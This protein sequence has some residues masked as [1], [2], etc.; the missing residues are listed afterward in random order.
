MLPWVARILN[1]SRR[2]KRKLSPALTSTLLPPSIKR[3]KTNIGLLEGMTTNNNS[4]G[5]VVGTSLIE[6]PVDYSDLKAWIRQQEINPKPLTP[7]QHRA[8]AD[9]RQS[10]RSGEPEVGNQDWISI[11]QRT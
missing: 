5:G 3:R 6:E 1:M 11:L 10:F 4:N 2:G 7:L 9:L 8:I